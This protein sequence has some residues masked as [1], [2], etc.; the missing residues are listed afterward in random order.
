[1]LYYWRQIFKKEKGWKINDLYV[2]LKSREE[3]QVKIEGSKR[4]EIID[5]RAEINKIQN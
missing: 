3:H 1:M 4:E 2:Y 5:I